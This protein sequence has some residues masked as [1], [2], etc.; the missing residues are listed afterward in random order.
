MIEINN[1]SKRFGDIVALDNVSFKA[2]PGELISL[3]GPNGAGKSTLI[4]IICGYLQA[5]KGSVT[6]I[7]PEELGY[8]PE[9]V[10]LYP[11]MKVFEYL[12][13]VAAIYKMSKEDFSRNLKEIAEKL[14]I[15][16]V[17]RQ[18]IG[19]LSKAYTRPVRV[20]SVMLHK[21]KILI[22]D[23]P[24]EGLDPNQKISLRSFLK[25]YA[26]DNLVLMSTHLLEEAEAVSSRVLLLSKGK[27][28]EDTTVAGLKTKSA[29]GSLSEA[30]YNITKKE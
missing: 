2:V 15:T 22:L 1:V 5:D 20:A 9:G 4:R 8:M 28:A 27:L 19:T 11:E 30:F 13:F 21:P 25:E 7:N 23:E 29:D 26:V 14:E 16:A 12:Q 6:G 17:L 24:T 10:P 18:N 3:L